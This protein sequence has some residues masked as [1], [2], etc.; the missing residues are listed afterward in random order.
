MSHIATIQTSITDIEAV[1]LA[2]KELGLTF[3]EN[4]KTCDFWPT[5]GKPQQHPCDHA[6]G[7]PAGKYAMELG[8]VKTDKGYDL[9]GD[10]LLH[11]SEKNKDASGEY[12]CQEIFGMNRNPLG[13]KYGKFLQSYGLNK[14]SL[15]ARRKG[16]LVTRQAGKN[17]AI[18]L[19]V[20]GM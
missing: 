8:L 4:Q 1:K 14:A 16:Y 20:T 19:V 5:G 7:L 2:C 12:W 9:V 17:G 10:N 3:K 18:K 11:L 6:I 13:E 15:E